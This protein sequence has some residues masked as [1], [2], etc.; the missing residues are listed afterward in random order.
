MK[1]DFKFYIFNTIYNLVEVFIIII[2]G[3]LLK[4]EIKEIITIISMFCFCRWI[5]PKP[6]HYKQWWKCF[7]CSSFIFTSLYL[8]TRID[9]YYALLFVIFNV[10]V[11]SG[12]CNICDIFM[13][14]GKSSKYEDI[15]DFIKYNSLNDDLLNFEDKI[16]KQNNLTFMIYKY[17]FKDKLTFQEISEKLDIETQRITEELEKIAFAIRI[18]CKI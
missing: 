9:I 12:K 1:K 5:F 6:K 10:F 3:F 4:L 16:S 15:N 8:L 2:I 14:K 11:L 18:Y 7:I 13:W 17:R